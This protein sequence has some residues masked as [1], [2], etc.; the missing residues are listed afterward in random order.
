MDMFVTITTRGTEQFLVM[1]PD[2]EERLWKWK[3]LGTAYCGRTQDFM[4][5]DDTPQTV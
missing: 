1:T 2:A 4:I 5:V 3:G